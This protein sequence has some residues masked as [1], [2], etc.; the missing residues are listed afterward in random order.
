MALLLFQ[1]L[2]PTPESK[3]QAKSAVEQRAAGTKREEMGEAQGWTYRQSRYLESGIVLDVLSQHPASDDRAKQHDPLDHW[4]LDGDIKY[5]L[6]QYHDVF[7]NGTK[8][9]FKDAPELVCN[10]FSPDYENV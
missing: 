10:I 8:T 7:R 1:F 5:L 6:N 3:P 9:L 4:L 2:P